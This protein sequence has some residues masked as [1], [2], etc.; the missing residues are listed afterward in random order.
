MK[1][2]HRAPNT[3]KLTN[4]RNWVS[5]YSRP[6]SIHLPSAIGGTPT[7]RALCR[8]ER[9]RE[10]VRVKCTTCKQQIAIENAHTT[11]RYFFVISCSLKLLAIRWAESECLVR[12]R[13][14][15]V[16]LCS[17]QEICLWTVWKSYTTLT[18]SSHPSFSRTYLS[19]RWAR[20]GSSGLSNCQKWSKSSKLFLTPGP[21]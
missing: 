18:L 9:G 5:Q 21:P 14:P 13:T 1:P 16:S 11:Y 2:L 4:K 8:T 15:V 6:T 17:V 19:S 10:S 3:S 20:D 7:V 12:T